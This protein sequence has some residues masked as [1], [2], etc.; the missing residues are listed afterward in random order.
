MRILDKSMTTL[1]RVAE[2]RGVEFCLASREPQNDIFSIASRHH[3]PYERPGHARER[4][5]LA[6]KLPRDLT[7]ETQDGLTRNNYDSEGRKG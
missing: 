5:V 4:D 3:V 6:A 2:I 7:S 1:D